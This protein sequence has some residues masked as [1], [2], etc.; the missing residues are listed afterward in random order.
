MSI[1]KIEKINQVVDEYFANNPSVD[2]VQ[3]K[4]L[5]PLFIK[6]GI[7]TQDQR[8]GLPIRRVL[9]ELDKDDKLD[10]MPCVYPER[11]NVNTN[12]YFVRK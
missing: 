1:Q 7:F 11:K 6:A 4:D 9:R 5:M 10:L 12:W 8:E 3:A 2:K